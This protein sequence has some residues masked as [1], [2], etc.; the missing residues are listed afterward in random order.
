[1]RFLRRRV[2]P[3]RPAEPKDVAGPSEASVRLRPWAEPNWLAWQTLGYSGSAQIKTAGV[4]HHG[5]TCGR[6]RTDTAGS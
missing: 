6:W 1:M 2:P 5:K 3:A 4:T